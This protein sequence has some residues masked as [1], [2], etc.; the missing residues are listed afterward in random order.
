MANA[1]H[2]FKHTICL[3]SLEGKYRQTIL[4]ILKQKN[5]KIMVKFCRKIVSLKLIFYRAQ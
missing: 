1:Y 3:Y 5:E 4:N 2:F